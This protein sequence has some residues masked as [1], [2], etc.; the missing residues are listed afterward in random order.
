VEFEA[1]R[2]DRCYE[3]RHELEGLE[4]HQLH[5]LHERVANGVSLG[6]SNAL[7]EL[8]CRWTMVGLLKEQ[9][10]LQKKYTP[11]WDDLK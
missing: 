3:A 7:M 1:E 9:R 5:A 11:G 8:W 10:R 2:V 4:H 6:N